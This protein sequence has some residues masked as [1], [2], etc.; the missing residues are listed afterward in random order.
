MRT[1]VVRLEDLDIDELGNL[2][3]ALEAEGRGIVEAAGV[4]AAD[5]EV[6][7]SADMRYVG[8]GFEIRVEF[9]GGPL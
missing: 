5:I 7:R 3:R 6:R 4:A 1:Y 8:Q 9:A 2:L